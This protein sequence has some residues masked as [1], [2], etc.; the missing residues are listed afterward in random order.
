MKYYKNPFFLDR[1]KTNRLPR[2]HM[3][4]WSLHALQM[5]RQQV[6]QL[7][8]S[9]KNWTNLPC[10]PFTPSL[11][12]YLRKTEIYS[13]TERLAQDAQSSFI[14]NNPKLENKNVYRSV[15]KKSVMCI[16]HRILFRY[17]RNKILTWATNGWILKSLH[18]GMEDI[19]SEGILTI[20]FINI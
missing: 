18:W 17:R 9:F 20:S 2:S 1:P 14:H 5:G 11:D 8:G 7:I 13:H 3:D 4:S 16:H 15:R 19:K 12:V 6:K 10:V